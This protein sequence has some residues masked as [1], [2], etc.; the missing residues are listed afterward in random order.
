MKLQKNYLCGDDLSM[1]ISLVVVS[2]GKQYLVQGTYAYHHYMQDRMD[3]NGWGCAYRSLQTIVS[4]FRHQ[5]YTNKPIPSHREIQEVSDNYNRL[6][7]IDS[8][9]V[10]TGFTFEVN[11]KNSYKDSR[12]EF[13][14]KLVL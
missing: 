1:R 12:A 11:H 9:R 6:K 7:N 3:D 13:Y 14:Y 8:F 5:G 4:W 10:G 2:E